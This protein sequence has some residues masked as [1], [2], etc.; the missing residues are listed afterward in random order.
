[1]LYL[2]GL[3]RAQFSSVAQS[4]PAFCDAMDCSTSGLPVTNSWSLL[5]LMVIESV[6]PASPLILRLRSV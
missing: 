4:C 3:L 6:T 1:M 2:K 5:K